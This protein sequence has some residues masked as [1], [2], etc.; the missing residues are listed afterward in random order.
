MKE[1]AKQF[2]IRTL[3]TLVLPVII[4]A[5]FAVLTNG[6]SLTMRTMTVTMRQS[7]IPI[8][9][10]MALVG[11][12]TL[13]MMDFSVGAVVI[14][15]AI[16]GGNLMV[17][18]DTGLPGLVIFCFLTGVILTTITGFLNNKLRVPTLVLTVG[19]ML[20]YEALPRLFFPSG[21]TVSI[22]Y[23]I[24]ARSPWI[25]IVFAIVFIIFYLLYN[26]AT[27]GHNI[28]ALGGSEEIAKSAGI[29]IPRIKQIGFIISGIFLGAAAVLYISSN[30]QLLNVSMF[31]SMPT[32][33]NAFMG[34]FL[35]M[36][37]SRYCNIAIAL[38]IGTFTMSIMTNGFI[39]MGVSAYIRDVTTGLLLL[40]LLGISANQ[41]RLQK[42]RMDR[43]RAK[44]ANTKYLDQNE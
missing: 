41:G 34:V 13:G 22:K 23:T 12:M 40:T 28:R 43:E 37:L 5:L 16:I 29:N 42:W 10:A 17:M 3:K 2:I 1:K 33:L 38:I 24:L 7:I 30:G 9:I 6:R 26:Y 19:I 35:A 11:N 18:T 32:L 4:I 8:L 44:L 15:S 36:F 20:V 21:A 25:F 39:A 31:G 14:A 27:Y